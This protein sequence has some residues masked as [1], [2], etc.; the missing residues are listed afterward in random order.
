MHLERWGLDRSKYETEVKT[1]IKYAETR[2][3]RILY[4]YSNLLTRSEMETYFG[5]LLGK[6][7]LLDDNKKPV[8]W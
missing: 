7:T 8:A 5:D 1:F 2:P 6:V 4:F 3:G